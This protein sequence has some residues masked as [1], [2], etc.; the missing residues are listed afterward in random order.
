[1]NAKLNDV[2]KEQEFQ[3]EREVEFRDISD[4]TN[5]RTITW[6]IIQMIVVAA[7][8][9]WQSSHLRN[10]FNEKKLR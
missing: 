5:K 10:F 8:C 1:M 7:A 2:R 4:S 9:Y 3:R 6:S